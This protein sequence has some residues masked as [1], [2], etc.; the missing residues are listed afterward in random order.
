MGDLLMREVIAL[1]ILAFLLM[2]VEEQDH[3]RL[4][5]NGYMEVRK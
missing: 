3:S 4:H 5:R 2:H 1:A